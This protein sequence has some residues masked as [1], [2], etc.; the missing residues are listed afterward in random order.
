M[1]ARWDAATIAR[2]NAEVASLW[3]GFEAGTPARVPVVF[4]FSKRFY[5]LTPWLNL[6]GYTFRDYFER[7]EVQW[8][9][10]LATQQ[11]IRENVS[12]DQEWGLP[13]EWAGLAPDFQNS[14]EAAWLGC[15]IEYRDGEVPDTRPLL[16]EDKG[17]LALL[18]IPDPLQG[19]I[20][21]RGME[22]RSYFEARRAK[23]G[24]LDRPVGPSPMCGGGTDGPF[25]VAC[26]LRGA[27]EF[28]L[29]LYEDPPFARELLGFIT[30]AIIVRLRAVGEVNGVTYPQPGWGFAD[31]S[32]QLLSIA[33][34][35]DWV[36]PHHRRLLAEFSQGGPNSIHLCGDVARLLPVLQQELNI[37]SFDT[38]F[39]VDLGQLRRTLG[40][41]AALRGNLHP[42]VLRKGPASLIREE[43]KRIMQSGVK[44][45]RKY[46]FC[47]GNNVAPDT[48]VEHFAAA[49]AAAKE[50]GAHP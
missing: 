46:V 13:N 25:T 36:L 2:H 50:F 1:A 8:E 28:C 33:Q 44:E 49:Y 9:V 37:Q 27:T 40:P 43:T 11:W 12:Q 42:E 10:Q 5:L 34:Y 23:E 17:K 48:P 35:R 15:T 22:F 31:D 47:E 24:Y 14:Y 21:A 30:D 20:M 45:G 32:I 38:G 7:P 29:D 26:N 16:R 18:S 3:A 41:K 19:G 6:Q 39:P 4:N